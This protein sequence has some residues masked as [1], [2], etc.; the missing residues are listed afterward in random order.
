MAVALTSATMAPV[1]GFD[2]VCIGR[3]LVLHVGA[4]RFP[5]DV[6]TTALGCIPGAASAAS[7]SVPACLPGGGP[8]PLA[9]GTY[10]AVLVG[11]GLA[12]PPAS[13]RVTLSRGG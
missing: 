3:P 8:P 7:A 11:R 1:V 5:T 4:N 12:L 13:V 9:T 2:A 10:H 6:V